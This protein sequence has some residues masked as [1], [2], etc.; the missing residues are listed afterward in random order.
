MVVNVEGI[1]VAQGDGLYARGLG[2]SWGSVNGTTLTNGTA[3][4]DAFSLES[5]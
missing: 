2:H 3:M 4:W 5:S 1:L